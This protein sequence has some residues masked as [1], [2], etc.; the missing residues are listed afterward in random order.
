MLTVTQPETHGRK[1]W[2]QRQYS[3]DECDPTQHS[4]S[5]GAKNEGHMHLTKV[6]L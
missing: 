6:Y 3:N 2:G 1:E 4:L 5:K